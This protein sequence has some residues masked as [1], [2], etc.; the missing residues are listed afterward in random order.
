MISY[1]QFAGIFWGMAKRKHEFISRWAVRGEVVVA[2]CDKLSPRV[3]HVLLSQRCVE[4]SRVYLF[5][6]S[7]CLKTEDVQFA[8]GML[9]RMMMVVRTSSPACWY[10]TLSLSQGTVSWRAWCWRSHLSTVLFSIPCSVRTKLVQQTWDV[11]VTSKP[12]S[13]I[14]ILHFYVQIDN[15]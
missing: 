6:R 3:R 1:H 9:G 5:A 2:F 14:I 12:G 15:S 10:G 7:W 4:L 13:I 11:S 8:E